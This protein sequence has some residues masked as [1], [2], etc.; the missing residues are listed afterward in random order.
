MDNRILVAYA[1]KSGAIRMGQWLPEAVEFV[2]NNRARL[3]TR[4]VHRARAEN[5][6]AQDRNVFCRQTRLRQALDF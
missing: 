4:N 2:K 5:R 3:S 6:D 1:S